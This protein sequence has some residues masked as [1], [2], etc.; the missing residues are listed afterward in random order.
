MFEHIEPI[1]SKTMRQPSMQNLPNDLAPA[2]QT[3]GEALEK[4]EVSDRI[5]PQPESH[6]T[7][8]PSVEFSQAAIN[9]S[10][11]TELFSAQT[12]KDLTIAQVASPI[13]EVEV[14]NDDTVAQIL[15]NQSPQDSPMSV[16]SVDR[17]SLLPQKP[18]VAEQMVSSSQPT[19][20]IE[21]I[22]PTQN[23][24]A[25]SSL[26]NDSQNLHAAGVTVVQNHNNTIVQHSDSVIQNTADQTVVQYSEQIVSSSQPTQIIEAINPTQNPVAQS[27]LEDNSQNLHAAGVTVVQNHNNTIVQ[28]SDSVIQ[29][30]TDQTVVQYSDSAIH[31][32]AKQTVSQAI[33]PLSTNLDRTL[34]RS[35][36]PKFS[37]SSTSA[38]VPKNQAHVQ[39]FHP[40]IFRNMFRTS[41]SFTSRFIGI[42]RQF[43]DSIWRKIYL[44]QLQ[45]FRSGRQLAVEKTLKQPSLSPINR[46]T[47]NAIASDEQPS[48]EQ[49]QKKLR[50]LDLCRLAFAKEL[51]R[52]GKFRGAIALA[53]Q[54]SEMSYLFKDAQMLIQ[55]WK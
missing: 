7:K 13:S 44:K 25:Q 43:F 36:T 12:S 46:S 51:A 20:I 15:P 53:E 32:P 35:E 38:I 28:H 16:V 55:S 26:E 49:Y 45:R 17:V 41:G 34:L 14:G 52:N 1:H 27:S 48:S 23:P 54:V 47:Y 11:N 3:L 40:S 33:L 24:V 37:Q 31:N 8:T 50:E 10:T 39:L 18:V 22:N 21:A 42:S 2:K 30:L 5:L 29:N 9:T 19:Q 6:S 4:V